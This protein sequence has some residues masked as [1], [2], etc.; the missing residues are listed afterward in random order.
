MLPDLGARLREIRVEFDLTQDE[1]ARE[2]EMPRASYVLIEARNAAPSHGESEA[3]FE[4]RALAAMIRLWDRRRDHSEEL[5]ALAAQRL[6]YIE[7]ETLA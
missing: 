5:R 7:H 6:A 3:H 4:A 2:L 1:V